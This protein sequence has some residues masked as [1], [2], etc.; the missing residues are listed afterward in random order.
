MRNLARILCSLAAASM[1]AACAPA[2]RGD[3]YEYR[4]GMRAQ[5]VEMGVIESVRYVQLGAPNTGV[6]TVGGAA[7]GGI[8]GSTIGGSGRANAAG[9]IAGAIIGGVVGNAVENNANQRNGIEVTVR[10]DSGQMIAIP[11]ENAG[12]NFRPGDRVRVLSDGR[13]TRVTY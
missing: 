4:Q 10:L 13:T 1:L 2:Q 9:A 7:I 12:E 3:V 5:T 8:A 6:G 11:Q